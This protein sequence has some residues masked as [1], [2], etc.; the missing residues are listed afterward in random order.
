MKLDDIMKMN[1]KKGEPI[2]VLMKN[3]FCDKMY[4]IIGYLGNLDTEGIWIRMIEGDDTNPDSDAWLVRSSEYEKLKYVENI[5]R[6]QYK[7]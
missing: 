4:K 5:K 3:R 7:E 6:L 2:E 1:L